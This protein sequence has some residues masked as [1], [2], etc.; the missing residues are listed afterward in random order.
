MKRIRFRRHPTKKIKMCCNPKKRKREQLFKKVFNTYP[1][2]YLL[3][4]LVVI[5]FIPFNVSGFKIIPDTNALY[6]GDNCFGAWA[7]DTYIFMVSYEDGL[8]CQRWYH[9][10]NPPATTVGYFATIKNGSGQYRDVWGQDGYLFVAAEDDGLIMYQWGVPNGNFTMIEMYNSINNCRSVWGDGTYIYASSWDSLV[11]SFSYNESGLTPLNTYGNAE[12]GVWGYGDRI[13]A[14]SG[15][16]VYSLTHDAGGFSYVHNLGGSSNFFDLHV[17]EDYV[18]VSAQQ[19]GIF[20]FSYDDSGTLTS[21]TSVNPTPEI[22][23]VWCEDEYVFCAHNDGNGM[24]TYSFDGSSFTLINETTAG[25]GVFEGIFFTHGRLLMTDYQH[26]GGVYV[27]EVYEDPNAQTNMTTNIEEETATLNAYIDTNGSIGSLEQLIN[28]VGFYVD[29]TDGVGP[30]TFDQ[31]LTVSGTYIE[32]DEFTTSVSN[33]DTGSLYYS[34]A[35]IKNRENFSASTTTNSFLTKPQAPNNVTASVVNTSAI[36]ISWTKAVNANNTIVVRNTDAH[37]TSRTDGEEVYNGTNSYYVVNDLDNG[38][39][40]YYTLWSYSENSNPN[41]YQYSDNST[42]LLWGAL[43]LNCFNENDSLPI[44]NWEVFISNQNGSQV[45]NAS[46]CNNYHEINVSL[47]PHG[48]NISISFNADNYNDRIYYRTLQENAWYVLNAYLPLE[49]ISNLYVLRVLDPYYAPLKDAFVTV[50]EY[51]NETEQYQTIST[52]FTDANGETSVNLRPTEQYKLVISKTNY[53]TLE[54]AEYKPDPIYYGIYYPK[55][56]QLERS[57]IE[58]PDTDK[59]NF[60]DITTWTATMLDNKSIFVEY[61]NEQGTITNLEFR[62]YETYNGTDDY[63]STNS[64]TNN[65]FNFY[66]YN[67]NKTRMHRIDLSV[68]HSLTG[69]GNFS[70]T[71]YPNRNITTSTKDD[72]FKDVFGEWKL[73]FT[74]TIIVL[75]PFFILLCAGTALHPG[76]GALAG[77]FWFVFVPEIVQNTPD[78]VR[79]TGIFIMFLGILL[80]AVKRGFK[81]L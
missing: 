71:V 34:R 21:I 46:N 20:A 44:S 74:N 10:T 79:S 56:F 17:T 68:N 53:E 77:G 11:L 31:N 3:I 37:P 76:G 14:L 9:Y 52:S 66:V 30:S 4:I 41:H 45:Y 27:Y 64:S 35:W 13:F 80:I 15:S 24:S 75:L 25:N 59:Y 23:Y 69:W 67:V 57:D 8:T 18:F 5:S 61:E 55:T 50:K 6:G 38:D 22:A 40:Y 49:N 7:N 29:K 12:R 78:P 43:I 58:V 32:H 48:N 33:L 63:K 28:G 81:N 60:W 51:D 26:G 16:Q 19:D 65:V 70:I 54:V 36:N 42:D 39:I 47:C 2:K 72:K 1:T 62:T 73:G